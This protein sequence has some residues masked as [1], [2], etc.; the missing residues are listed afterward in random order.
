MKRL[1][2]RL[3]CGSAGR[4]R[5]W[6]RDRRGVAAIEMA[7]IAPVMV[8][9]VIGMAETVEA[10]TVDRKVTSMAATTADL[11]ARVR[12]IDTAGLN[13][14]FAA[15][16]A[17]VQPFPT[18]GLSIRVTSLSR[19]AT[20]QVRV[21]W[22]Q[23]TA[24]TTPYT[25]GALYTAALPTGVLGPNEYVVFAEVSYQYAGPSTEFII[26]GSTMTESYFAKP[27]RS[28]SVLRCDNLALANP[29]CY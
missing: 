5:G 23:A 16:R 14:V 3:P 8:V 4:H 10:M 24:G 2:L 20:D 15:A 25:K 12:E 29:A 17:I 27:R 26:Q 11:V 7:L 9:M 21:H 13:D 28:R 1:R 18:T 6:L 19:N 22:S